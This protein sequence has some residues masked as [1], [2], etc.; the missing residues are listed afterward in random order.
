MTK[1]NQ[2]A[3]ATGSHRKRDIAMI[4]QTVARLDKAQRDR[5][6]DGFMALLTPQAVW[7]TAL[8]K[9][10]TGWD[11]INRFTQQVLTPALG[12]EY[13]SY[14]VEHISF[15][16]DQVA[17][18]NV[19]QRPVNADNQPLPGAKEGRPLY[20]MTRSAGQWQIAV[21]QNTR[22]EAQAIEDQHASLAHR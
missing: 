9:R 6:P 18:V 17:A 7:V 1:T 16:G 14:T 21:G 5:D 10:M 19:R 13:A 20:V 15:L 12:D 22:F 11:E 2:T 4:E 8:G 3:I